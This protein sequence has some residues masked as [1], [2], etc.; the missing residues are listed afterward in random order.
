MSKRRLKHPDYLKNL[1][2]FQSELN[3]STQLVNETRKEGAQNL[4]KLTF[5]QPKDE[6]WQFTKL[7][8]L[9][10]HDFVPT[11][12]SAQENVDPVELKKYYL[13]ESE[14]ARIVFIDGWFS[15][16]FSDI[17]DLPADIEVG[18]LAELSGNDGNFVAK[19][20]NKYND[21][22]DD[23]F[24]QFSSAFADQGY[25]I[26]ITKE[27]NLEK[28]VQLLNIYTGSQENFFTT[29]RTLVVAEENSSAT[30]VEEHVGLSDNRYFTVPVSEFRLFEGAHVKH[31]KVQNDSKSAIHISRPVAHVA[32]H[33]HYQ[34]YTFTFV[35]Q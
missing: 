35:P 1:L 16:K 10:K 5:P 22:R 25:C 28:P 4:N 6:D 24:A 20:F 29:N 13:A 31:V 14:G 26:L 2:S 32:S 15:E 23:V 17:T 34:S 8:A 33:A 19:H 21:F 12:R 27:V 30:I 3:E 11:R 9:T 18:T 7:R